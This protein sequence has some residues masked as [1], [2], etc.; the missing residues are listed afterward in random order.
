MRDKYLMHGTVLCDCGGQVVSNTGKVIMHV[1]S[2]KLQCAK[3]KKLWNMDFV[4]S[5]R[6]EGEIVTLSEIED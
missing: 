6:E 5:M 2:K 4:Y 3:C 1:Q